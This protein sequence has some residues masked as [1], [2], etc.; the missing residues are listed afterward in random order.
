MVLQQTRKI[1][2]NRRMHEK[3]V[4]RCDNSGRGGATKITINRTAVHD[5]GAA[6]GVDA[7]AG[8]STKY[9]QK[10]RLPRCD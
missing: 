5:V 1:G 7:A 10:E 9:G 3:T 2:Q 4:Q 8:G 6:G